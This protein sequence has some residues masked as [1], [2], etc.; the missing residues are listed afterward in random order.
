LYRG[1]NSDARAGAMACQDIET[2]LDC[3]VRAFE[4]H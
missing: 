2:Q 1:A 4:A 3:I